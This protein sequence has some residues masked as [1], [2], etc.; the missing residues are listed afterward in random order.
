M[1]Q[2]MAI[3]LM[4]HTQTQCS[5]VLASSVAWPSLS[6]T[7][8]HRLPAAA[9]R[10]SL[11]LSFSATQF[12]PIARITLY[13]LHWQATILTSWSSSS[14]WPTHSLSTLLASSSGK[15]HTLQTPDCPLSVCLEA[16]LSTF[17]HMPAKRSNISR[18]HT[19]SFQQRKIII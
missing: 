16:F 1:W 8:S 10:L 11:S 13:V 2:W 14:W 4:A 7:Q 15:C 19:H 18:A 17:L 6:Y 9:A 5:T 12:I 3:C